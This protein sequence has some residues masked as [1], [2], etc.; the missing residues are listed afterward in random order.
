M[1]GFILGT[2]QAQSQVFTPDG[3]RLVVTHIATD[4]CFLLDIKSQDKNGY[5]SL[6]LGY[7]RA[8]HIK[9][10]QLGEQKKAGIEAP[11]R[12]LREFRLDKYA[13]DMEFVEDKGRRGVKIGEDTLYIGDAIT[14]S[15]WFA[16]GDKVTVTGTSKGKGFQ[17]GMKRHGF[18]G[19]PKTHGQSDRAR[20]PGSIGTGTTPGRVVKGKKMAGRMGSDRV[21]Q[22]GLEVVEATEHE[23]IVKGVIPGATGWFVEVKTSDDSLSKVKKEEIVVEEKVDEVVEQVVE[24]QAPEEKQVE[25][26]QDEKTE[27]VEVKESHSAEASRDEESD[28]KVEEPVAVASESTDVVEEPKDEDK[29]E[30]EAQEAAP[31]DV[32]KEDGKTEDTQADVKEE[33]IEEE[34]S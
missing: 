27:D 1:A 15:E 7:G 26:P 9:K 3:V 19:G 4:P 29:V 17:G 5:M 22:Q 8:K 16:A 6:K 10:P 33:V 2:K 23:L 31:Q 28:A 21:A 34:K 18:H 30:V 11:L 12:F 13:A 24:V 25:A 32:V 20:A 14:P